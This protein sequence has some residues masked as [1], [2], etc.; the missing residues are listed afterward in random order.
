MP[1]PSGLPIAR[2]E[3]WMPFAGL[4]F[5]EDFSAGLG[6]YSD[7]KVAKYH[8]KAVIQRMKMLLGMLKAGRPAPT[9]P[10]LAGQICNATNEFVLSQKGL[11]RL[12]GIVDA[13]RQDQFPFPLELA[14]NPTQFLVK[15][16]QALISLLNWDGR[17][18]IQSKLF[19]DGL[20]K[21]LPASTENIAER[22]A[23]YPIDLQLK[24]RKALT[25]N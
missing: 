13:L 3:D 1:L 4:P 15:N 20:S 21:H 10:E 14:E 17:M 16:S 24:S 7:L 12:K 22:P 23:A 18:E 2:P 5:W 9:W 6:D 19:V 11:F 25:N 8:E